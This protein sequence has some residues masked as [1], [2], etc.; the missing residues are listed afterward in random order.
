MR[1]DDHAKVLVVEIDGCF[2][3][4][5]DGEVDMDGVAMMKERSFITARIGDFEGGHQTVGGGEVVG[6][7]TLDFYIA[8]LVGLRASVDMAADEH[9]LSN[10]CFVE[11]PEVVLRHAVVIAL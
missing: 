10:P 3:R 1:L 11:L 2:A 6:E 7:E 4:I 5:V 9:R 8:H